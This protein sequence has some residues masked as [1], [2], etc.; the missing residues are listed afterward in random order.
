MALCRWK[1]AVLNVFEIHYHLLFGVDDGPK[2]LDD[3][4]ALA[5]ASIQEGVTHIVAT[6]HANHYY[7]FRPEVNRERFAE[8][9]Q[10]LAGRVTLGLG[11]DFNLSYENIEDL[12]RGNA[13]YTINGKQY[14]LVEFADSAI[15]PIMTDTFYEMQ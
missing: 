11:C 10:R 3:S 8:L 9:E 2:T 5:E 1:D 14:L 12:R 13:K 4:L 7:A 15:S 6:P